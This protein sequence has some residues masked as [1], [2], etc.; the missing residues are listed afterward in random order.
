MPAAEILFPESRPGAWPI[1]TYSSKWKPGTADYDTTPP[2]Y[3]ADI[4]PDLAE[5][6]ARIAMQAFRL[7]GCRDYAR[8]DFR[9]NPRSEPFILE[10]NPNPEISDD[11]CFGYIL[12]SAGI[13]FPDFLKS[14]IE[15][16]L[17]RQK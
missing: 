7:L 6:L 15:Q 17:K 5:R 4:T 3:P 10:I 14:L 11:A 1:L 2:K 12:K 13:E 9:V 16:T 8:V